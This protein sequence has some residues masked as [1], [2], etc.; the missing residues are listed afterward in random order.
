MSLEKLVYYAQAFHLVLK[1]EPLFPDEIEAWKWGPVVPSVYKKYATYGADSIVLPMDGSLAA[2]GNGI[3]TF[4]I[5]VIGFFCRHTA[6]NLSRATH[7]EAPWIEAIQSDDTGIRQ[8]TLK[9]YY[10][11]LMNEGEQALSRHELLDSIPEP[12]WSSFYVAGI[13]WRKM[14]SHP[15]YDGSL[16]KQLAEPVLKNTRRLPE[17]FYAP[18]KGRDFIEF[19]TD[20]DIDDTLRRAIS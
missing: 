2:I 9:A 13:C 1:D 4:L 3:E 18:V 17:E 10:R 16:A 7:L 8:S 19:T 12:R 5:Q 15:F 20:E 11:S 14:A 6:V